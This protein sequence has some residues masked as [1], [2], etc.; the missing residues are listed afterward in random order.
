M[1]IKILLIEFLVLLLIREK[2]YG[3]KFNIVFS[4]SLAILNVILVL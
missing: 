3:K 1:D 4:T 2:E